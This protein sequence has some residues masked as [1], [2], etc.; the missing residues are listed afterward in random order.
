MIY[1]DSLTLSIKVE[2]TEG[3]NDPR[4]LF[5]SDSLSLLRLPKVRQLVHSTDEMFRGL[6]HPIAVALVS[7]WFS[8]R[9]GYTKSDYVLFAFGWQRAQYFYIKVI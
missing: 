6:F 5:E 1:C 8:E 9:S 3:E 4:L 7:S 2:L